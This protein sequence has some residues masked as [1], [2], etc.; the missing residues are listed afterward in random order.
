R[1]LWREIKD[2]LT[3]E[4]WAE[5]S[6]STQYAHYTSKGVVRGMW[7]AMQRLGFAGGN[8]IE[9]GAGI[10]VFAGMM[11]GD[12]SAASTY[13]GIEFEPIAGAILKQLQPDELIR[14]ESY[15][16]STLPENFY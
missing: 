14:V 10:G 3:A 4:E 1:E 5:A 12:V 7:R 9:P 15:V 13:T 8:I 2:T 11:P 16:D 6:R